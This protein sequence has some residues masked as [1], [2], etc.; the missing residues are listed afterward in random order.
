MNPSVAT[1]ILRVLVVAAVSLW[2]LEDPRSHS[3]RHR[4]VVVTI[5]GLTLD[6]PEVWAALCL[7]AV[8]FFLPLCL[9]AR[10]AA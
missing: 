10:T 8:V 9:T 3:E 6:K 4:P 2:V 1:A 5:G 7:L